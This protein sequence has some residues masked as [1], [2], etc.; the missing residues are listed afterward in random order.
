MAIDT[1][2]LTAIGTASGGEP[3][4]ADDVVYSLANVDPSA[5]VVMRLDPDEDQEFLLYTNGPLQFTP[6]VCAYFG[7]PPDECRA[8]SPPVGSAG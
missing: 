1:G 3:S 6:E 2:D 7:S 4:L 5:V 8:N